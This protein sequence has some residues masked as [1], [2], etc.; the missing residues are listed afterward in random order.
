MMGVNP[1]NEHPLVRC[2]EDY[3][4]S[5]TISAST[6]KTYKIVY[7]HYIAYLNKHQIICAMTSDVI[8]FRERVKALGYSDTL[9]H[10]IQLSVLMKECMW[11]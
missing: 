11:L 3:L 9:P 4:Q 5:K 8:E 2:C 10:H 7:K 1:L 6:L